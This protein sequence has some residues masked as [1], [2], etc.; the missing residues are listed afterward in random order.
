MR[1]VGRIE[2]ERDVIGVEQAGLMGHENPERV[3]ADDPFEFGGS[4]LG[5][6]VG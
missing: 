2:L 6:M 5:E 3:P 4:G 1:P